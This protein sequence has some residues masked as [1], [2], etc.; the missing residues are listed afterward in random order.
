MTQTILPVDLFRDQRRMDINGE[1]R[2]ARRSG[3]VLVLTSAVAFAIGPVAAKIALD[4]GSNVLT[5]V[6]LRGAIGAALLAL[7]VV[8]LRQ[9]FRINRAA[10]HWCL[11]C[12]GFSALMVY[13]IIGA[14]ATI[15]VSVAI[16]IFF[17][18]PIVIAVIMHWR[19]GDRLTGGKLLLALTALAGLA[20]ALAPTFDTLEPKGIALAALAAITVCGAILCGARAQRYA[21]STQVNLYVTGLGAVLFALITSVLD[22]WSLPSNTLGWLGVAGAGAGI[23]VGLLTFFASFRY[24]SPVRATMLSNVEP[25]LSILLAALILSQW[26]SP[27]QWI[28]AAVMI[29]AIV[30][31]EAAGRHETL[32]D[33]R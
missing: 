26:P 33:R 18:H 32:D 13:G 8:L 5:V 31:F 17:V 22:G 10:L 4:N 19:G 12:G 7:L 24:L 6:T 9:G 14:V 1:A 3:L 15:P 29:G 28:G 25:L 11:L 21:T 30:L 27:T 16:L 23:A 2:E 20:L